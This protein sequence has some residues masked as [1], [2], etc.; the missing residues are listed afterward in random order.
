[1][2]LTLDELIERAESVQDFEKQDVTDRIESLTEQDCH[3]LKRRQKPLKRLTEHIRQLQQDLK[4]EFVERDEMIEIALACF[5]AH[6]PMIL[7]GPPGTA[8]SM[9]LRRLSYGLGLQSTPLTIQKLS[10]T[11]LRE[12]EFSKARGG[13][14]TSGAERAATAANPDPNAATDGNGSVQRGRRYYEVLLTRYSTSDEVLGPAHLEMMIHRA[15]FYRQTTGLLPEAEVAFLDEIFKANSAILNALLSIVN[16]RLFYN[17]G[18]PVRV[19]LCMIFG[20]SNEVPREEELWA[21]FD[22]FPVRVICRPVED[23]KTLLKKAWTQ[24]YDGL[25]PKDEEATSNGKHIPWRA[26]VNHFRL[27]FRATHV[28]YG[29]RTMLDGGD[30]FFHAYCDPFDSL[31]REFLISDRSA[32][33]LYRAACALALL[34]G[35]ERTPQATELEVFKYCFRDTESAPSLADAVDERIRRYPKF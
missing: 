19:P 5:I 13:E 11:M 34:R 17:A 7:L 14:G 32:F 20:A 12:L 9:V 6:L 28:L 16:E 24:A 22:R 18:V 3:E 30:K 29:G 25:L 35:N 15:V 31:K 23:S 8:K 4:Q 10:E 27:L 33:L 1:M 2:T 21:L 26:S